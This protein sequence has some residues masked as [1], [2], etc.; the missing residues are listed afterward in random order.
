M[1]LTNVLVPVVMLLLALSASA[2]T[3]QPLPEPGVIL[4][5]KLEIGADYSYVRFPATTHFAARHTLL[6]GGGFLIYNWNEFLGLRGEVQAYISNKGAFVLPP[7]STFPAGAAGT[8]QGNMITYMVGPE[9]KVRSHFVQPFGNLLVGGAHTNIYD[10]LLKPLCQPTA[11]SCTTKAPTAES[12]ALEFGAGIDLP[13]NKYI[14][15]RPVQVDYL[16]TRF[17]NPFTRASIQN[18]FHY[19]AG[20]T[21]TLAWGTY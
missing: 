13:I 6:G 5:P 18:S 2:Q 11:G 17:A 14:S 20:L 15:L 9:F 8:S 21:F 12:F 16:L 3:R 1:K 7:S 4:W 10:I 19:S